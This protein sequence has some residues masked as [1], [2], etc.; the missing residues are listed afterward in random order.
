MIRFDDK[1]EKVE[2]KLTYNFGYSSAGIMH[3]PNPPTCGRSLFIM[4][5]IIMNPS[6]V[7]L[8]DSICF[9]DFTA[10]FDIDVGLVKLACNNLDK[11]S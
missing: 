9:M 8:C 6:H 11:V 5:K 10:V 2:V 3:E 7:P 4:F 1:D